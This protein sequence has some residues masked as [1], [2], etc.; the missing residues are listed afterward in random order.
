M[1][2]PNQINDTF[3]YLGALKDIL[4]GAVGGVITYL[5][6]YEKAK[7]GGSKIVF[8][9]TSLTIN[10][11]LGCFVAYLIG[12]ALPLDVQFRDIII[13]FSALSAYNILLL[14]ESRFAEWLLSKFTKGKQ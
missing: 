2:N 6:A 3:M 12:T 7:R 4:L 13:S 11:T 10:I 14:V 8:S 5:F 1:F 9:F